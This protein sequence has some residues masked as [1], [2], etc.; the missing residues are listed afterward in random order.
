MDVHTSSVMS[1]H[2]GISV[3]SI[4]QKLIAKK[5]ESAI[6]AY[7]FVS[8]KGNTPPLT[9]D[10]WFNHICDLKELLV[11]IIKVDGK[12]SLDVN[13][14]FSKKQKIEKLPVE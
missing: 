7:Y 13:T 10:Q 2:I 11:G 1:D 6:F 9:H 14:N 12:R 8:T 5:R 3:K 4:V